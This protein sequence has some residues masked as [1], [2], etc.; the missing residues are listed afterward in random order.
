MWG[1][2]T[3]TGKAVL[4][5]MALALCLG[6][7]QIGSALPGAAQAANAKKTVYVCACAG[8]KS[9]PCMAMSKKEGK[10]PCGT[11]AMKEVPAHGSWAKANRKALME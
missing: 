2:I 10:C 3:F 8:T 6:F 5:G 9:C 7:T 4:L 1:K 11:D